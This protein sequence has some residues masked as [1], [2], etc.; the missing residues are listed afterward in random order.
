[1]VEARLGVIVAIFPISKFDGFQDLQ[2]C[3]VAG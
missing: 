2:E 1:M 3:L